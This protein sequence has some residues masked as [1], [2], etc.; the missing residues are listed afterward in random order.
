MTKLKILGINSSPRKEDGHAAQNSSTRILLSHALECIQGEAN[1][2]IIDL[3]DFE[4]LPTTVAT[5]P[6]RISAE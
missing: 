6:M 3:V 1:T 4:I 5:V 2:E